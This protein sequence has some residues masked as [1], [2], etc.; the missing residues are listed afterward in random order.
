MHLMYIDESGD[1]STLE[2]G[3]SKVL[4]VSGCIIDEK[5]KQDIEAKFR[6][7]KR[8]YYQNPDV[9]IKSN[10]LRYANPSITDPNKASPIK[11]YDQ[12][13][14]NA[15][16]S[17]IQNFL[18][19]IPITLI[20]SVID[21]KGY[22]TKYPSQNPYEVAYIFLLERFQ[23]FLQYK[24]ALGL[25]IIDPREGRVIDKKQMDKE[26][27]DTHQLLRWEKGGFWKPCPRIIEK[28]LFSDSALTVGIQISDL[29]CYPIYNIFQYNKKAGEYEWFDKISFPK[30]YYHS[31]VAAPSDGSRLGPQIDGTGLKFFPKETKKDFRFYE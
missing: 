8:K 13:Q 30:F 28:I 9:E 3:G 10:F 22:W 24:N 21:K 1:T 20:S 6:E 27:N 18:K 4:V 19:T 7:I 29:F 23:T 17:D 15:L 31:T 12:D 14:Y 2:R 16:Q 26:L 5:D 25:C 11:L